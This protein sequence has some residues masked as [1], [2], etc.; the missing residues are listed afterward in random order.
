MGKI[1]CRGRMCKDEET[2]AIFFLPDPG[3]DPKSFAQVNAGAKIT[4]IAMI[5]PAATPKQP[6]KTKT[7]KK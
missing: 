1:V 5:D 6:E 7:K 3:C 2:G 4:G